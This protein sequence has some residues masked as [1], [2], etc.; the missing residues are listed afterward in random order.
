MYKA[1][2]GPEEMQ[3]EGQAVGGGA[4]GEK[5]KK[6]NCRT[7]EYILAD[8]DFKTCLKLPLIFFFLNFLSLTF[9]PHVNPRR[10][11]SS[12]PP[13]APF[14]LSSSSTAWLHSSLAVAGGAVLMRKRCRCLIVARLQS[15]SYCNTARWRRRRR[16][17]IIPN[18]TRKLKT[19]SRYFTGVQKF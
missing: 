8:E 14:S 19:Q 11:V 1:G 13:P 9:S 12:R 16:R 6:L 3:R 5:K 18:S 17:R 2:A 7:L 10:D 15:V 4:R